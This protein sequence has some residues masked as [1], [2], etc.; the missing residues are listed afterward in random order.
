VDAECGHVRLRKLVSRAFTVRRVNGLRPRVEEI[1]SALLDG[2]TGP[3]DLISEFAYPLPIAVI[4]ELVGSPKPTGRC[5]A[6]RARPATLWSR[7]R[8]GLQSG[9]WS[10]TPMTSSTGAVRSPPTTCS[11]I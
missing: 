11:P 8:W 2:V 7:A 3:V 5:G 9:R 4:C 6:R 1:T 10:P